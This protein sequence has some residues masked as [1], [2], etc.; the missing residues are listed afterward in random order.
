ML[1]EYENDNTH[2]FTVMAWKDGK[3]KRNRA[4]YIRKFNIYKDAEK[5]FNKCVEKLGDKC[6]AILYE[7]IDDSTQILKSTEDDKK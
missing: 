7:T 1:L 4:N 3:S 6:Y 2:Y 5:A